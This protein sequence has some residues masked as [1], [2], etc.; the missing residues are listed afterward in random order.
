MKEIVIAM[1]MIDSDHDCISDGEV[2]KMILIRMVIHDDRYH[3]GEVA[4]VVMMTVIEV[5]VHTIQ[6]Q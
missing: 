3:H 2:K 4:M 6:C 5:L 1:R